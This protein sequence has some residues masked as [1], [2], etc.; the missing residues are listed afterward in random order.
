MRKGWRLAGSVALL[1][2][3]AWRL[4]RGQVAAAFA[5]LDPIWW[6]AALALYFV[7]QAV[8]A[9]RWRMFAAAV[10]L[11]GTWLQYLRYY[12]VGMFFNLALPTSVG[13]DVVRVWY[14]T[15]HSGRRGLAA[16]LSVVAERGSGL[17]VLI[18]VA[19]VAG[20]VC[21][22]PLPWWVTA[23][24]AAVGGAAVLGVAVLPASGR[25]LRA[26]VFGSP[27]YDRLR[28]AADGG[29]TYLRRPGLLAVTAALSVV[30]Q[31]NNVAVVALIG[32]GLGLKVSPL[33]YGV[34]VPLV[35]L[36]TLLPVSVNGLGLREAGTVL[37][38]GPLGVGAAPAVTLSV[39]TFAVYAAASLFGLPCYLLD[40]GHSAANVGP[41]VAARAREAA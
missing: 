14:L 17:L 26:R 10:G 18:A 2:A 38:L 5:G 24:V 12:F 21:P 7:T 27:K 19:C 39:L 34:L 28:E 40:A 35:T 6:A 33:Y 31:V 30:V 15:R 41:D 8:S 23:S 22:V 29:M 13:G 11:G 9:L 20:C 16:F 25:V 32:A 36:L 3:L 4:D 1:G 37:L